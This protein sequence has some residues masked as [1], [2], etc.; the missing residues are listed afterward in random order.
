MSN[1]LLKEGDVAKLKSGS[2]L[3]TVSGE[4]KVRG[5]AMLE[6]RWWNTL[7]QKCEIDYFIQSALKKHDSRSARGE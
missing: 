5:R 4:G 7:T 1:D 2:A 6:C 3:M